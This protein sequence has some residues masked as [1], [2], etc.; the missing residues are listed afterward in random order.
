[1]IPDH[2]QLIQNRLINKVAQ[3][4]DDKNRH[5]NI[6]EAGLILVGKHGIDGVFGRVSNIHNQE[7]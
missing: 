1:M 6:I 7:G 3:Q 4:A 2:R 5:K